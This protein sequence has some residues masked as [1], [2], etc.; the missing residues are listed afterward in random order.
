MSNEVP[1]KKTGA[2]MR[3][4]SDVSSLEVD[5]CSWNGCDGGGEKFCAFCWRCGPRI[6]F[7]AHH[8]Y[9]HLK[10]EHPEEYEARGGDKAGAL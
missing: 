8:F 6:H 2:V 5:P 3:R 1:P 7:C 10:K 4:L 9:R